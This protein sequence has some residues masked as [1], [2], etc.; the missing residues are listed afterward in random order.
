[1]A[2][3]VHEI[4]E[5]K[6]IEKERKKEAKQAIELDEANVTKLAE[7]ISTG[8][9]RREVACLERRNNDAGSM[10]IIRLDDQRCWPDGK[11]LVSSRPLKPAEQQITLLEDHQPAETEEASEN[12][13]TEAAANGDRPR[14]DAEKSLE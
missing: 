5:A 11:Q 9:T 14:F 6:E 8:M 12:G 2:G 3:L 4:D 7:E 10:E 1:M 13:P